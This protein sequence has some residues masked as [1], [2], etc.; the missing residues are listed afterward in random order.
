MDTHNGWAFLIPLVLFAV[1]VLVVMVAWTPSDSEPKAPSPDPL[2]DWAEEEDFKS[3]AT[4]DTNAPGF[5]ESAACELGC[6]WVF[7]ARTKALAEEL[8]EAHYVQDHAD[9]YNRGA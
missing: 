1:I 8:R 7:L 9:E 5:T 2:Y 4:P 6:V 3:R